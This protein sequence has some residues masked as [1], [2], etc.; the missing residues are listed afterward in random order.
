VIHAA[1]KDSNFSRNFF[2]IYDRQRQQE[3]G[4][5]FLLSQALQWL[6]YNPF[7][8]NQVMKSLSANR[9]LSETLVGVIGDILPAK[10]VVSMSFLFQLLLETIKGNKGWTWGD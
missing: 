10:K 6:V 1:F 7:F 5:K 8:C 4:G 2:S 9:V 3:F